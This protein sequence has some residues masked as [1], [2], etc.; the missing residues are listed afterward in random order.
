MFTLAHYDHCDDS[1]SAEVKRNRGI[2]R[3][4]TQ[5]ICQSFGYTPEYDVSD[6]KWKEL[7]NQCIQNCTIFRSEEGTLLRL[8]C[9]QNTWCLSTHKRLNAFESRWSSSRS[10][11]QLFL[12]AIEYYFTNGDG[13]GTLEV[14]DNK[15]WY[16]RF[17][18]TLDPE[19]VYTFLLR[20]NSDTKIVCQSPPHP[21]VYFAGQFYHGLRCEGN[22]TLLPFPY[23]VRFTEAS[24]LEA[25]VNSL[26]PLEHQ[27]VIVFHTDQSVFKVMNSQYSDY[28]K[29]R[30]CEPSLMR[31]YFRI[32]QSAT[33]LGKFLTIFPERRSIAD[34]GEEQ[35]VTLARLIH[36]F[37]VK[38][39]IH[40]EHIV[41]NKNYFYMMR[42]AHQWHTQDRDH[43]I[44]TIPKMLE[45]LDQQT[46]QFLYTLLS[47][48]E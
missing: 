35:I 41:V 16:N 27:G 25:Y 2:I 40:K 11:G 39:F 3:D 44:V 17:C 22:P 38:R 48:R 32:R 30:G 34:E 29:L 37:Y 18:S 14:E 23:R 45:L 42:L 1:S 13:K 43:H 19:R 5:I 36:R 6:P 46:P 12:D 33:D 8:Y 31:A 26:N 28:S 21:T 10:F 47:I 15:D 20:T 24:E 7:V 9:Y 4:Q